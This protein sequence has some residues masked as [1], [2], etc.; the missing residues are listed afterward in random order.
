MKERKCKQRAEH[1]KDEIWMK[2]VKSVSKCFTHCTQI[3]LPFVDFNPDFYH[4]SNK[5]YNNKSSMI[6]L[7]L[8]VWK[9]SDK[10]YWIM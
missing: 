2:I 6:F 8:I 7:S 3:K 9:C 5:T 4:F 10:S 1:N